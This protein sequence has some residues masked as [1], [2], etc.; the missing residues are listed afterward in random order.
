M[1]PLPLDPGP[2]KLP[3]AN[4]WCPFIPAPAPVSVWGLWGLVGVLGGLEMTPTP[5]SPTPAAIVL[6]MG[7]EGVHGGCVNKKCYDMANH[8]RRSQY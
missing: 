4:S 6:A 1:S 7:K 5:S 2:H 3:L 8:L